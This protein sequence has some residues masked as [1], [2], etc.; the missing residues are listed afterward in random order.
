LTYFFPLDK[1]LPSLSIISGEGKKGKIKGKEVVLR[2][3]KRV[4]SV[5]VSVSGCVLD[6]VSGCG[7]YFQNQFRRKEL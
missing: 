3:L 6:S 5:L 2:F 4:S 7:C 1:T